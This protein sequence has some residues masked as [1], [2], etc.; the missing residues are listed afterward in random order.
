MSVTEILEE[1]PKLNLEDRCAVWQRLSELESHEEFT[2]T[3]EMQA[4]IEE[5]IRS[6]ET[7]PLYSVEEVREKIKQCAHRSR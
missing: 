1:L 4:A 3:P 7:E 5:G 6:A 2:P